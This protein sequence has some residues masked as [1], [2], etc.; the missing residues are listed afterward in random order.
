MVAAKRMAR[1]RPWDSVRHHDPAFGKTLSGEYKKQA[2]VQS[3]HAHA[4]YSTRDNPILR[5]AIGLVAALLASCGRP[6][7][8]RPVEPTDVTALAEQV[9]GHDCNFVQS[10]ESGQCE[11]FPPSL[12]A[13]I[14]H[15]RFLSDPREYVCPYAAARC[16]EALGPAAQPAVPALI[17]ALEHG[18]N[19]YD[20][21][22]GGTFNAF[23]DRIG[24]R[25]D[26]G[27]ASD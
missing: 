12:L 7:R 4:A 5:L 10:T 20:S 3:C 21:G 9:R 6:P 13:W 14:T 1:T 8:G 2:P 17:E 16:L 24:S 25:S 19:D 22:D 11:R 23:G 18:P 15:A 26:R 27:P